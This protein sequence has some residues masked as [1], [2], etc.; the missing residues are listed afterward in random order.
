MTGIFENVQIKGGLGNALAAPNQLDN[1][2]DIQP[3]TDFSIFPNPA[4]DEVT[5]QLHQFIG[6]AIDLRIY[7]LTGQL[8]QQKRFSLVENATERLNINALDAGTYIVEIQSNGQQFSKK[9]IVLSWQMM[10]YHLRTNKNW[11]Y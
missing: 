10:P 9:L 4:T 11:Y 5:L 3:Q 7:N 2:L 6:E 8:I 1:A